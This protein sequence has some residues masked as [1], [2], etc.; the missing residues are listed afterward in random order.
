[1]RELIDII[2][3]RNSDIWYHGTS[4]LRFNE[5]KRSNYN[6]RDLYL[7]DSPE[8]ITDYYAEKAAVEDDSEPVTV[9]FDSTK[10]SAVDDY[11]DDVQQAGQYIVNGNVKDAII[12][13]YYF[14]DYGEKV[15]LEV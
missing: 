12:S 6:A 15:A 2:E 8:G 7:G 1:M 11:H 9:E 10:L 5:L 14:D 4:L 3:S 13:A